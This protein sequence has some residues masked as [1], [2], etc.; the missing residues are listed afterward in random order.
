M[1]LG[2]LLLPSARESKRGC[3]VRS[4]ALSIT[5]TTASR[6]SVPRRS[7]E[8]LYLR[9]CR[10]HPS[11]HRPKDEHGAKGCAIRR[12]IVS[13]RTCRCPAAGS[14]IPVSGVVS[15][16]SRPRRKVRISA[17]ESPQEQL[18][19]FLLHDLP[20]PKGLVLRMILRICFLASSHQQR[21]YRIRLQ[22]PP[23][24]RCSATLECFPANG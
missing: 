13:A 23:V 20:A 6:R 17:H 21:K 18:R 10:L 5:S 2:C 3:N 15:R 19:S 22:S 1:V 24:P 14:S 12:C 8:V 9:P 7:D 16:V 4:R 11:R